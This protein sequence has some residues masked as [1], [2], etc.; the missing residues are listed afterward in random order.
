MSDVMVM[1]ILNA[2]S[3]TVSQLK[4][5]KYVQNEGSQ[6]TITRHDRTK[7]NNVLIGWMLCVVV[8]GIGYDLQGGEES[9]VQ[10][11][12]FFAEYTTR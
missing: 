5:P 4:D 2:R 9:H 3:L 1:Q 12:I 8:R 6:K 11:Q 7:V 10:M